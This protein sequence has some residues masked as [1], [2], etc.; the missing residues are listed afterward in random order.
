MATNA[1]ANLNDTQ[2]KDVSGGEM[3]FLKLGSGNRSGAR[4]NPVYDSRG[5]NCG[6]YIDGVL[7]YWPCRKCGRPTH[8]G[9]TVHQCDKC[10]DW[11]FRIFPT[12]YN[13][14]EAQLRSESDAN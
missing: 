10:D 2:L 8:M 7:Y 11:F 4:I 1:T 13:G 3:N 6:E 9:S 5:R 14:T 12:R